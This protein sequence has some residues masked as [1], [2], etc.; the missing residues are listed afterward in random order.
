MN[1]KINYATVSE[2]YFGIGLILSSIWLTYYEISKDIYG[3]IAATVLFIVTVVVG[4]NKKIQRKLDYGEK[5]CH[6]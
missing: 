1:K 4:N 6:G 2:L 5:K 3:L